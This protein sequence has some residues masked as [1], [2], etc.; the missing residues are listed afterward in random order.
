VPQK[1]A[2][3]SL[4]S[5][6]RSP[7]RMKWKAGSYSIERG[8]QSELSGSSVGVIPRRREA[9]AAQMHGHIPTK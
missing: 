8:L 4:A 9:V 1:L 7:L 6:R 5:A 3:K 2:R